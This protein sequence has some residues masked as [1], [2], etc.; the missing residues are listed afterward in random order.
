MHLLTCIY[1]AGSQRGLKNFLKLP[2]GKSCSM[3]WAVSGTTTF[4]LI[5]TINQF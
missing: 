1:A 4:F 3:R 5:I 2:A